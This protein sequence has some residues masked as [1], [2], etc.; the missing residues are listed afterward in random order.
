MACMVQF[1]FVKIYVQHREKMND[2]HQNIKFFFGG[3]W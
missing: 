3:G 2:T 1:H